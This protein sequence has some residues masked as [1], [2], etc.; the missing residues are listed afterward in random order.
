MQATTHQYEL[1]IWHAT[2]VLCDMEQTINNSVLNVTL[3]QHCAYALVS[4]RHKITWS[5]F[6]KYHVLA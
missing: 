2:H 4:S 3:R 6:R 5:G 1:F